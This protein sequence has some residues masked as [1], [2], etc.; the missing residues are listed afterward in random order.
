V[1]CACA[2]SRPKAAEPA[3]S[4]TSPAKTTS[5]AAPD[6]LSQTELPIEPGSERD[7]EVE[8]SIAVVGEQLSYGGSPVGSVDAA[9]LRRTLARLRGKLDAAK[10]YWA[11]KHQ[12]AFPATLPIA[13]SEQQRVLLLRE[14]L[15]VATA[16][17]FVNVELSVQS[18]GRAQ[19]VNLSLRS[20]EWQD[21]RTKQKRLHV[22][23]APKD[24]YLL[25]WREDDTVIS[26][27]YKELFASPPPDLDLRAFLAEKI[28]EE[29]LMGGAHRAASDPLKDIA[30]LHLDDALTL[31]ELLVVTNALGKPKR[32]F[33]VEGKVVEVPAF[34]L[35]VY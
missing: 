32:A 29:W 5:A 33:T 7:A 13:L 26:Q 20:P 4:Q 11:S 24:Q 6:A 9:Q 27:P 35:F 18:Q 15:M 2:A 21:S 14:L 17:E 34:E 19:L 25:T 16:A 30:V 3:P 8:P 10:K 22:S 1:L 31:D 12:R 28:R 23:V